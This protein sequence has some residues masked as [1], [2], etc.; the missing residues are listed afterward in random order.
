MSPI[1]SDDD[2]MWL[3]ESHRSWGDPREWSTPYIA[4]CFGR[5][6]R[7]TVAVGPWWIRFG[8]EQTF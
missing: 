1:M 3:V 7:V 6:W 5:Y 2:R 8:Y 4:V